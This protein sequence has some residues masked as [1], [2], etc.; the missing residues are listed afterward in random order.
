M[1][2]NEKTAEETWLD[3]LVDATGET[4]NIFLDLGGIRVLRRSDCIPEFTN[5]SFVSL[6]GDSS[7]I[8]VGIAASSDACQT[9]ASRFLGMEEDDDELEHAEI[10][11][12]FGE[13]ANVVA[14]GVKQQIADQGET[15]FLGLPLVM[16]QRPQLSDGQSVISA[17][18]VM[19][20]IPV[21]L[22]VIFTRKLN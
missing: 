18:C 4:S 16:E 17:E 20:D 3:A 8:Q 13:L 7:S 9:L 14:G 11:D 2:I 6:V 1:I 5:A 22:L 15:M 12:A 19:G 21:C 10:V